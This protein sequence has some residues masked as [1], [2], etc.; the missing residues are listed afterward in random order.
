ML[1]NGSGVYLV[2]LTSYPF[3]HIVVG[4]HESIPVSFTKFKLVGCCWYFYFALPHHKVGACD[5]QLASML[6]SSVNS[7]F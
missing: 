7:A 4:V 3:I 6:L 5:F 2:F 1:S